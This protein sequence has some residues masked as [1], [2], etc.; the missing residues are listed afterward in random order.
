MTWILIG[1]GVAVLLFLAYRVWRRYVEPWGEVDEV[2]RAILERRTPAKFL[3]TGN[4]RATGIGLSAEKLGERLRALEDSADER[5]FSVQAVFSA[6]L[7]GLVVV[8]EKRRVRMSN[9][10]FLRIFGL[11]ETKPGTSLLELIGHASIDRLVAEA[12]QASEPRRESIQM[13][14]GPSA[15]RE[16][17]VSAVPLNE[18]S[19]GAQGVVVLFHDVTQMRQVE[20]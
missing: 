10:A 20:E 9:K 17:E 2:L 11:G 5:E 15:G 3:M 16:L 6:M 7:D 18:N 4:T 19:P 1:A 13:S 14:R 8:D 12:I